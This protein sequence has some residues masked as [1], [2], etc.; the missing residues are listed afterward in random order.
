MTHRALP[1]VTQLYL[2]RRYFNDRQVREALWIAVL[3]TFSLR[4]GKLRRIL[5]VLLA[6]LRLPDTLKTLRARAR[7][8]ER[9]LSEFPRIPTLPPH[10]TPGDI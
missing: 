10:T 8:S 2:G 9:M 6:T 4:G 7:E 3:G 1:A 5:K